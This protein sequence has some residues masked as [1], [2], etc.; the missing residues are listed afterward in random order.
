MIKLNYK[1]FID[2]FLIFSPVLAGSKTLV[3]NMPEKIGFKT[4]KH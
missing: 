1:L 4:E 3:E 2:F